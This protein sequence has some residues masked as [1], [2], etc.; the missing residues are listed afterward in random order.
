MIFIRLIVLCLLFVV[1]LVAQDEVVRP[2]V[3]MLRSLPLLEDVFGKSNGLRQQLPPEWGEAIDEKAG[4]LDDLPFRLRWLVDEL[5]KSAPRASDVRIETTR[6]LVIGSKSA[7][8]WNDLVLSMRGPQEDLAKARETL[9]TILE[10]QAPQ[11]LLEVRIV[12]PGKDRAT[13]E[14][15]HLTLVQCAAS[16]LTRRKDQLKDAQ[17]ITAPSLLVLAGD[18][19]EVRIQKETAYIK[20][21]DLQRMKDTVIADPVI[22]VIRSGFLMQAVACLSADG[23]RISMELSLESTAL[24]LPIQELETRLPGLDS[25]MTV[26]LPEVRTARWSSSDL[27]F[28]GELDSA[29]LGWQIPNDEGEQTAVEVWITAKVL[30]AEKQEPGV[31]ISARAVPIDGPGDAPHIV[32]VRWPNFRRDAPRQGESIEVRRD[33]KVVDV[34]TAVGPRAEVQTFISKRAQARRGDAV[35]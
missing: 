22:D 15:E 13:P 5:G 20:D 25:P 23:R 28:E 31:V 8:R 3:P 24:E 16:E 11:I 35:R 4:S 2:D 33:G 1:P 10:R 14:L 26:Q 12:S 19:A 29:V 32:L 27:V 30:Q 9:R 17:I 34:L 18:D 21:F 6:N 7:R